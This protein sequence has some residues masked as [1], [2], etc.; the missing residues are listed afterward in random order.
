MRREHSV[1]SSLGG[2][3]ARKAKNQGKDVYPHCVYQAT[4]CLAT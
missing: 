1:V 3:A 2:P 4:E